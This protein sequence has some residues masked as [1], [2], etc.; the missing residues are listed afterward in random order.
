VRFH[1]D[2]AII[3][4]HTVVIVHNGFFNHQK[5]FLQVVALECFMNFHEQN[6]GVIF[7]KNILWVHIYVQSRD[8]IPPFVFAQKINVMLC[9]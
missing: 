9:R 6:I 1:C 5:E 7:D 3:S 2:A 4:V 8:R